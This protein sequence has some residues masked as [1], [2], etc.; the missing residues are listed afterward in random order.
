MALAGRGALLSADLP[1]SS[2]LWFRKPRY[3]CSLYM[4]GNFLKSF[5]KSLGLKNSVFKQNCLER[6]DLFG[7][8]KQSQ[9]SFKASRIKAC[10]CRWLKKP[11]I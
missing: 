6:P 10:V 7:F 2:V 5:Q 8:V 1:A 11:G 9:N 3:I 4:L